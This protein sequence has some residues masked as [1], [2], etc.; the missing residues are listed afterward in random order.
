MSVS[1]PPPLLRRVSPGAW[2]ALAWL[3]GTTLTFLARVRLPGEQMP[4]DFPA[5]YLY[6]WD[7]LTILTLA[8]GLALGGS[9]LLR[10]RPL[11]GLGLVLL[12][13]A[14]ASTTLSV[15]E[16]PL[17]QFVAADVAVGFIAAG[18]PRR[19]GAAA[20]LMALGTLAGYL[21]ARL[22]MGW[23]VGTSTEL[24]VALTA[25]VAWF[26]GNATH[27]ARAHAEEVRARAA[28]QAVSEERLRMARELHDVVA[29]TM[30][31]VALQAGAARRVIDTQPE[32]A[33]QALGEVEA[34][35]RE[36]LSGLR[37]MLGAL[38]RAQP[39]PQPHPHAHAHAPAPGEDMPGLADVERLAAATTAAG[40][41]V[42]VRW[43]GERRPLPPEIDLS[44]FRIIQES[45]TNVVRHAGTGSCA[46][47]VACREE[48]L[49]IEVVDG[50]RGPGG[51]P[52]TGYGLVGMRERV[53][54]LRG[55]FSAGPGPGGGFRVAARLP[56][57]AGAGA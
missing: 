38:R 52:D 16:I 36:T 25:V 56:V 12:G 55:E 6:R 44:A 27:E 46:V 43:E 39:Q 10:R 19:T 53:A 51:A 49:T 23:T 9:R 30:G 47:T 15:A 33:R 32:R 57:P 14:V 18:R 20:L 48:E 50:G 2:T 42:E 4:A 21:A 3:G 40:V 31:I 28:E 8:T 5:E 37:R 7:G 41:R 1:P 17:L 11:T 54:L 34:A 29:H 22:L 26:M 24:T 45:V 35:S 13:S